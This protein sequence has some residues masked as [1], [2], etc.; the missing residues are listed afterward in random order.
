MHINHPYIFFPTTCTSI[1]DVDLNWDDF[2]EFYN[3]KN[4][5]IT[6]LEHAIIKFP[7]LLRFKKNW[8]I[9]KEEKG[10]S[11]VWPNCIPPSC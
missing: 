2:I 9:C 1:E 7:N 10:I 8:V 6:L 4:F 3:L 5:N 11:L